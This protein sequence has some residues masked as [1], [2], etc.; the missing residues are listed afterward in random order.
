VAGMLGGTE[1]QWEAGYSYVSRGDFTRFRELTIAYD[2]PRR[3][4]R[5]AGL[6]SATL[7]VSARNLKL[8]TGF[9]GADPE[10]AAI[11]SATVGVGGGVVGGN[12]SGIPQ[13]RSWTMRFDLG[14]GGKR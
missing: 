10:S 4:Y 9:D 7:S 12:A 14:V 11:S 8:W 6:G 1:D 2:L 13:A 3:L 5:A